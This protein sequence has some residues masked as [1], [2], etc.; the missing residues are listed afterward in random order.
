MLFFRKRKKCDWPW[1]KAYIAFNEDVVP[2]C[3]L[4]DSDTIKMG[5]IFEKDF[6]EIWNSK[7]YHDFRDRIRTH[8]LPDFCKNCY[9]IE[10]LD[11]HHIGN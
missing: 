7:E 6:P 5:N 9:I 4:G 8:N 11:V 10:N 3:Y 1:T 2:C